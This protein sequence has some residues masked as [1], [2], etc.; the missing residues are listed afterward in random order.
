MLKAIYHP[1]YVPDK[2]WFKVQLLLWDKIYRIVPYSVEN[3]FGPARIADLWNLDEEYLPII[4]DTIPSH[5]YLDERKLIIINQLREI[6][7]S[8]D[9]SFVDADH[10]YLN[11]AKVPDWIGKKLK[12]YDLRSKGTYTEWGAEHYLVRE[13]ATNFIMSCLAHYLGI[14]KGMSPLTDE[15]MSCF[16]TFGNQ[17]GKFGKEKPSGDNFNSFVSGVFDIMVPSDI[18]KLDF[19]DVLDIRNEY[20]D[21][22]VGARNVLEKISSEF[23][24]NEIVDNESADDAINDALNEFNLIVERFK[25]GIWR[26][27]FKDWRTQALATV[28]GAVAGFIAG[29]PETAIAI[30]SG[31]AGISIMNTIAGKEES[32]DINKMVQYFSKINRS[33]EMKDFNRELIKYRKAILEHYI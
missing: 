23:K 16:A 20:N 15:K 22:R 7:K 18:E 14:T 4:Q 33:I 25:K 10:F 3:E 11:T 13:D 17:I 5:K 32:S 1:S 30:S 21:L 9:K 28:L 19:N 29:G 8:S 6:S 12:D 26:R 27:A 2:D 24:L 31:A